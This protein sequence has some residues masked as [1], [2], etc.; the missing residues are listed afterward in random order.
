[1]ERGRRGERYEI[2]SSVPVGRGPRVCRWSK[3]AEKWYEVL[4][5][6]E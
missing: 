5:V 3:L 1:M 4:G 2:E 6:Q